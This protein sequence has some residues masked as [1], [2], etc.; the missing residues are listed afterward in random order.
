MGEYFIGTEAAATVLGVTRY[1]VK[2]LHNRGR[3]KDYGETKAGLTWHNAQFRPAEVE[4][5]RDVLASEALAKAEK[6]AAE[7]AKRAKRWQ[8]KAG[9]G[10]QAGLPIHGDYS[11]TIE[12]LHLKVDEILKA[13]VVIAERMK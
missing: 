12:S 4:A 7:E 10:T 13:L 11:Q 6:K 5:L 1:V 2:G 9:Q 8:A 3:L